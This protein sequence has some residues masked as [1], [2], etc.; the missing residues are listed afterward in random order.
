M[1]KTQLEKYNRSISLDDFGIEGQEKLLNSKV[2]IVGVGGLGNQILLHLS[3]LG[4]GEFGIAD[5]DVIQLSNLPRQV[6]YGE[7]DLGHNK[8]E[9]ATKRILE[10]NKDVKINTFNVLVTDFNSKEL[11]KGYDLVIEATDDIKTKFVVEDACKAL[12]IPFIVSGVNGYQGQVMLVNKKSK[13]SFKSL[14]SELP[15]SIEENKAVFPLAV[16]LVSDVTS[17][18]AVKE[19]LN[20]GEDVIDKL[21]TVDANK[22]EIKKYRFE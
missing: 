10:K 19:L 18:L 20:S 7:N 12:G 11:F 9:T 17:D 14:F 16:S 4:V 21:I 15:T 5:I 3:S 8:V 6:L 22:I 13:Y 2:F 1:N